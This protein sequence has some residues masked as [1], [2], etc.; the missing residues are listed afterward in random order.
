MYERTWS[1]IQEVHKP[2]YCYIPIQKLFPII[3]KML[4]PLIFQFYLPGQLVDP[5]VQGL[6]PVVVAAAAGFEKVVD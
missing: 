4:S 1:W 2:S 6:K 5:R 3:Y